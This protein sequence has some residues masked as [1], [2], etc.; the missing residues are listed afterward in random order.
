MV[1]I[2]TLQNWICS[3]YIVAFTFANTPPTQ[4]RK[5]QICT[6]MVRDVTQWIQ[7]SN[8]CKLNALSTPTVNGITLVMLF[9]SSANMDNESSLCCFAF[10][11]SKPCLVTIGNYNILTEM[12]CQRKSSKKSCSKEVQ[13][14]E[15][16]VDENWK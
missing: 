5:F 13:L 4:N 7:R 12:L 8:E 1:G 9:P 14:K 15:K 3:F 16:E 10:M 2:L 6:L 11:I